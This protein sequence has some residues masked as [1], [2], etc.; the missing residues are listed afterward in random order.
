MEGVLRD[1][2]ALA[3]VERSDEGRCQRCHLAV[4]EG[5]VPLVRCWVIQKQGQPFPAALWSVRLNLLKLTAAAPDAAHGYSAIKG[6]RLSC[7]VEGVQEAR[8]V[9]VPRAEVEVEVVLSI[10]ARSRAAL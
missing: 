1:Q 3:V 10:S 5:L 6:H 2:F 4:Y 8:D 9:G 7:L